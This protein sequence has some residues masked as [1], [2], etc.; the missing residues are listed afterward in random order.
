LVEILNAQGGV[1]ATACTDALGN[2]TIEGLRPGI[3]TLL[4]FDE[5]FVP[6]TH[7]MTVL[8]NEIKNID[9]ILIPKLTTIVEVVYD[10]KT[11]LRLRNILITST[12]TD[13]NGQ[14]TIFNLPGGIFTIKANSKDYL[15]ESKVVILTP[16]ETAVVNF[17]LVRK[18]E[19][20]SVLLIDLQQ[21][22]LVQEILAELFA[23]NTNITS[24]WIKDSYKVRIQ[25]TDTQI[26][27]SL[28]LSLQLVI[29]LVINTIIDDVNNSN[30]PRV[31]RENQQSDEEVI[32][33]RRI[34]INNSKNVTVLITDI[35]FIAS[36]EILLQILAVLL[37]QLH[38][39]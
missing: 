26:S 28:Q 9:M 29:A 21:R 8:A 36:I 17:T 25:L 20:P 15:P 16:R 31:Q 38:V 33:N 5:G 32:N 12:L 37:V 6:Y 10:I 24:I 4:V 30:Q 19:L 11:G 3:Y 23:I 35:D 34:I 27:T 14:Y 22:N 18:M 39:L 1:V 7:Q 13:F 2:F